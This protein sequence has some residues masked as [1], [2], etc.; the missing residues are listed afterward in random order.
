ME[1]ES[2]SFGSFACIDR[3]ASGDESETVKVSETSSVKLNVEDKAL[4]LLHEISV[5][6]WT[7]FV[8]IFTIVTGL[9]SSK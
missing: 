6:S 2:T 9:L 3:S 1:T 5:M 8:G 4:A 7:V